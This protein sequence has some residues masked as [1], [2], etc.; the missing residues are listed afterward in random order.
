MALGWESVDADD[1]PGRHVSGDR[2]RYR[3]RSSHHRLAAQPAARSL[4]RALAGGVPD[5]PVAARSSVRGRV[6]AQLRMAAGQRVPG[7]GDQPQRDHRRPPVWPAW[8]RSRART[9]G[10]PP[11]ASRRRGRLPVRCK[12]RTGAGLPGW[13]R[14]PRPVARWLAVQ[15]ATPSAKVI[16]VI[17]RVDTPGM[18]A[19]AA[20]RAYSTA[21]AAT[22]S[23]ADPSLQLRR[24]TR[25]LSTRP[26]SRKGRLP[27]RLL[28]RSAAGPRGARSVGPLA[29]GASVPLSRLPA[30]PADDRP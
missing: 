21:A 25:L 13:P 28:S 7:G 17:H 30:L 22:S 9:R 26:A 19:S 1:G 18:R 6:G 10:C 27:G 16:T 14:T 29:G 15:A 11:P 2:Y 5:R 20:H 12:D 24:I 23:V 4:R 3:H 8:P